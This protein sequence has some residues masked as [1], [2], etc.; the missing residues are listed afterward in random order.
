MGAVEHAFAN[1]YFRRPILVHKQPWSSSG[2]STLLSNTKMK[3]LG[4]RK[5]MLSPCQMGNR[6]AVGKRARA[7]Y[8]NSINQRMLR[9]IRVCSSACFQ[10]PYSRESSANML[11]CVKA[12]YHFHQTHR[13]GT[14]FQNKWIQILDNSLPAAA[15]KTQG[16]LKGHYW[17]FHCH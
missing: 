16:L 4:S 6:V 17:A 5:T 3:R 9:D 14:A 13:L 10:A 8:F 12:N 1:E 2:R 15:A 7:Y 11:I